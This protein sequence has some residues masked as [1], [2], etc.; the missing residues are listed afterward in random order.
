M[1]K[2][3]NGELKFIK[4]NID[5]YKISCYPLSNQTNPFSRLAGKEVKQM[6]KSKNHWLFVMVTSCLLGNTLLGPLGA[7]QASPAAGK[8]SEQ[9]LVS[10]NKAD[11]SELE[12]I[13]GIG[14]MLAQRI[15]QFRE[16]N[17]RFE[18]LED[19]TR[20]PGIGPAKLEKIKDQITL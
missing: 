12:S 16:S 2:A 1:Q 8:A 3:K 18:H 13:R 4:I 6:N 19:L 5:K 10:I 20:V 7:L 15:V 11:A 14:P 9:V 17:G